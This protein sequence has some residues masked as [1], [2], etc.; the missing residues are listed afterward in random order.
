MTDQ[1]PAGPTRADRRKFGQFVSAAARE[2][3]YDIDGQ[4]SGGKKALAEAAGMGQTAVGRML[5]GT[6]I[7]DPKYFEGLAAAL[8]LDLPT[9]L[10][11]SGLASERALAAVPRV[12][13]TPEQA[14][15]DLG[16]TSARGIQLF[17]T[18]AES[19]LAQEP[20]KG[21]GRGAA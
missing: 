2:A 6:S 15:R 20:E 16:I 11:K 12:R 7:P 4:R 1:E 8:K 13:P 19:I 9:L 10:L 5:S 17:V 18:M 14:A 3:G 21:S